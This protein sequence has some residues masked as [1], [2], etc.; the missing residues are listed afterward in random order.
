MRN[1]NRKRTRK[2]R[3]DSPALTGSAACVRCNGKLDRIPA[4]LCST[5]YES[6]E[7]AEN[8]MLQHDETGRML[9]WKRDWGKLRGYS[10]IKVLNVWEIGSKPLPQSVRM[11]EGVDK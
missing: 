5:C 1:T 4:F 6:D 11:S 2:N 3:T 9:V 7:R 8:I 10:E